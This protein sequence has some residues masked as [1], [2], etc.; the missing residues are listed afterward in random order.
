METFVRL[1]NKCT[2]C[3]ILLFPFFTPVEVNA[4][5]A[6]PTNL[7]VAI[8]DDLFGFVQIDWY[9]EPD[10]GYLF[11]VIRKDGNIIDSVDTP[12]FP[13]YY[14]YQDCCA[15]IP[16]ITCYS[17]QAYY[18]TGSSYEVTECVPALLPG[19]LVVS[20]LLIEGWILEGQQAVFTTSLINNNSTDISFWFTGFSTGNPPPGYIV[21]V[22]P[23]SGIIQA[24][25][26]LNI[27]ITWNAG[28]YVPGTYYQGLSFESND[29]LLPLIFLPNLMHVILPANISGIVTDS[30]TGLSMD[31]VLVETGQWSTY[32]LADGSY[33]LEVDEGSYDIVFSKNGYQ[34]LIK[35]IVATA[36]DTSI[37]NVS[38]LPEAFPVPWVIAETDC[39]DPDTAHVSWMVPMCPIEKCYDDGIAE[40]YFA[41]TNANGENAV[42]FT[43]LGYPAEFSSGRVY[44]GDGTWPTAY[45]IGTE[46]RIIIYDEDPGGLPGNKMDSTNVVV[47]HYGW[48]AFSGLNAT[49]DSGNF[50][51]SMKQL[52][53]SPNTAPIGIDT[54][55]PLDSRS[56]S[57]APGG[58][59]GLS[60]YQDFMIRAIAVEP[61]TS[62]ID[63]YTI[64]RVSD[65]N[66]DYGPEFGSLTI[67]DNINGFVYDDA[68]FQYL[69]EAWYAYAVLVNY[70]GYVSPWTYS[71]IIG[72]DMG[73]VVTFQ[74]SDC[75]SGIEGIDIT[76]IG[77]DYPFSVF[78]GETDASG[79]CTFECT[80]KGYYNVN[81]DGPGIEPVQPF[82]LEVVHDT[83]IDSTLQLIS[84]PIENLEFDTVTNMASWDIPVIK[85]LDE[86]FNGASFPPPG[87]GHTSQGVGW[88]CSAN[89]GSTGFYIPATSSQY[90]YVNDNDAG[91][92]NNGCCDMLITPPL[93]L[94]VTDSFSMQFESYFTGAFGQQASVEYST[95]YGSTWDVLQT[96]S[97]SAGVWEN[98]EI[99]LS[100][101]SG[102]LGEPN[103]QFA[104]HADDNGAQA[105]GWAIDNISISAGPANNSDYLVFCDSAYLSTVDTTY[106]HIHNL[107]YGVQYTVC[108]SAQYTCGYSD[109]VCLDF[110]S[111]YLR[112][113]LWLTGDTLNNNVVL[114]W[115]MD[116][117][118]LPAELVGYKIYRDSLLVG[119]EPYVG[120]NYTTYTLVGPDP[121]CSD[122]HV[123]AIYD[124]SSSGFPG[125]TCESQYTG[126]AR[127]CLVYGTQMPVFED[128]GSGSFGTFWVPEDNWVINGQ[129]GHPEPAAEFKW[130]PILQNYSSCLTSGA[131][132]GIEYENTDDPY[133][134]G[135]FFLEFDLRL[136]SVNATGDEYFHADVWADDEWHT[137]YTLNN[138]GGSVS[139]KH[140]EL[141]ISDITFGKIFKVRFITMGDLSCDI[142]S[143]FVDNIRIERRCYPPENLTVEGFDMFTMALNWSPPYAGF[144]G[145]QWL[146]WDD[147]IMV[148]GVGLNGGGVFSVASHWDPDMINE[149]HNKYIKSIRFAPYANAVTTSFTLKIWKGPNAETLLYEQDLDNVSLGDWNL[150]AIDPPVLLDD[151]QELWFGYTCDSP[152]NENPA[153]YD[154]GPGVA[155][156]GDM[157]TLDG[158]TWEPISNYGSQF[159]LNWS[160]QALVGDPD[161]ISLIPL[162]YSE[163]LSVYTTPEAQPINGNQENC[164]VPIGISVQTVNGY[165]IYFNDDGAGYEY[166]DFTTDTFY[167]HFK[168]QE[169]YVGGLYC[170]YIKAVVDDC[171]A[172]SG[173]SCWIH[174]TINEKS[175]TGS[176]L[177]F[178][179]PAD[180]ILY[181]EYDG[182]IENIEIIDLMGNKCLANP[183]RAPQTYLDLSSLSP[184]IYILRVN[185][186]SE[187]IIKKIVVE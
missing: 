14:S 133:M 103:V 4:Q 52:N 19:Q 183:V 68:D 42:K 45:W 106:Y 161:D 66:P 121:G 157:I 95:D 151:D 111:G 20:P 72:M 80:W 142:L 130:D 35:Y 56:Y 55:A 9:L 156:Y 93:D 155:G 174:S 154:G 54:D 105:S 30:I 146:H 96:I 149:F 175:A 97:P 15:T 1:I 165:R 47:T 112:P 180:D 40:D 108:V 163:D 104:F 145:D 158:L 91:A 64:A 152:D 88:L 102:M 178:P 186:A 78:S 170:Y 23:V 150:V 141:D 48:I 159:D 41:W 99:D 74:F 38:L 118:A 58:S 119:Y 3:A 147:G 122:Y 31:S 18:N 134:A 34:T 70:P 85:V 71:N 84:Y 114:N 137:I 107:K 169:F 28:G 59:W 82:L 127:V 62:A 89:G 109:W 125:D 77:E 61:T 22:N 179:N 153:G 139:W 24:N 53:P 113:P 57:K 181:V 148:S 81:I 2:I 33:F 90:A 29:P 171:E 126:P 12:V 131:I 39:N 79:S 13:P 123:S 83:I 176:L 16:G 185:T 100:A 166:L 21:D 143:W 184:G 86:D 27:D 120:E 136:I 135:R 101:L 129:E 117:S 11:T 7:T 172:N 69:P 17:V 173:E 116:T 32:T 168:E 124:L 98:I 10:T 87:W 92:V 76:M 63:Y 67:L 5:Y 43:P 26:Y 51:L 187:E 110:T 164:Y 50:F 94:R 60:V 167:S 115:Y 65:F 75:N 44:V 36:Q 6:P 37:V 73:K 132:N 162:Q 182:M 138:N 160:L 25:D 46:F 140:V 144:S 8:I 177:V 128:W 49:L